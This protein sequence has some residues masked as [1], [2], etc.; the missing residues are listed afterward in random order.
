MSNLDLYSKVRTPDMDFVK[1]VNMRG[2]FTNIDAQY[3][4]MKATEQFGPYGKGFG[5]SESEL[6]YSLLE[7]AGVATHKATFFYV[8]NGE[9]SEFPINNAIQAKTPKGFFDVD[10]AKKV[11]T[12]TLGKALS[13]LGFASDVY[14]GMFDDQDYVQEKANEQA[15]EKADNK[16]AE[17]IRQREEWQAWKDKELKTM[18]LI[19]HP[20]TLK[21]V[22]TGYIRKIQRKGDTDALKLFEAKYKEC[23]SNMGVNQ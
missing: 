9:R 20:E 4:I 2:G 1:N 8:L 11:E 5:L 17:I 15:L 19:P 6:D 23:L 12:N 21:N 7:S 13:K 16:D 3:L 22:Y 18:A 10:F 14:M